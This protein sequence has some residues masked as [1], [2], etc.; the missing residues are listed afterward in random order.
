MGVDAE[1]IF[2]SQAV[3]PNATSIV[4]TLLAAIYESKVLL[5]V[6][7]SSITVGEF[8]ISSNCF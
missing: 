6:I 3:L 5:A 7:P 8:L 1:L 4:N 2:K